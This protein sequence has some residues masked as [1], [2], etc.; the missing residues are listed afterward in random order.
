[1]AFRDF[2]YPKVSQQLGVS[3]QDHVDV[4]EPFPLAVR[5]GF[6]EL[7]Q[8]G[9]E[10]AVG[11]RGVCSEKAKSEFLVAPVLLE[12]RLLARRAFSIFSGMELDAHKGKKLNGTCDFVLTKGAN[13]HL[14][15]APIVGIVEAKNSDWLREGWGQCIAG[16]AG[17]CHRNQRDGR[18]VSKVLGIVTNGRKWQFMQLCG[19][20][21]R[22]DRHEC[23][24][25]NLPNLFGRFAQLLA[26]TMGKQ[27]IA[28]DVQPSAA[29]TAGP[30]ISEAL[31]H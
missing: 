22:A 9:L 30:G 4:G 24:I 27:P 7:I 25:A 18:G 15:D 6:A 1:M 11:A 12:M 28:M 23:S 3:V 14:R 20:V 13:Q 31:L 2:T 26:E 19:S 5:P 16:M 21:V 17:A 10:V 29:P 8:Q